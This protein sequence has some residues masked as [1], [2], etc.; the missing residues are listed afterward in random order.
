MR[1]TGLIKILE[2]EIV[3]PNL[4]AD[5]RLKYAS[6]IAILRGWQASQ[7]RLVGAPPRKAGNRKS[8]KVDVWER[9]MKDRC[10]AEYRPQNHLDKLPFGIEELMASYV[11]KVCRYKWSIANLDAA[12][13]HA[14]EQ[15]KLQQQAQAEESK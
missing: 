4:P 13:Q 14:L 10:P 11:R 12:F 8:R 3:K 6:E 2:A 1:K 9:W 7:G 15:V 5:L